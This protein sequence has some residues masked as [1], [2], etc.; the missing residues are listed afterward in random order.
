MVWTAELWAEATV[1][2]VSLSRYQNLKQPALKSF[3]IESWA[4]F[5]G[6]EFG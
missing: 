5:I 4:V 6:D 2:Q 1:H 3:P